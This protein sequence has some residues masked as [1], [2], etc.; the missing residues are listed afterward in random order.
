MSRQQSRSTSLPVLLVVFGVFLIVGAVAWYVLVLPAVSGEGTQSASSMEDQYAQIPRLSIEEAK[1]AYDM[2]TALFLDVRDME[3][4]SK[5][6][7]QGAI[8]IPL[9][10]LTA[11]MD[12]LDPSTW[13]ITY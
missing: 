6:H 2:G 8:S 11:R 3:S 9:E 7:V 1:V 12:E 10:E 13:I 5:G 4:Y